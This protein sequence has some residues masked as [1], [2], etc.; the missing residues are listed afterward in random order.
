ML[1]STKEV[2]KILK[3]NYSKR[4]EFAPRSKLSPFR[5][6]VLPE[7]GWCAGKYTENHKNGLLFFNKKK[8]KTKKKKK[9]TRISSLLCTTQLFKN[10]K[11]C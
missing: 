8:K 7:G 9:K 11:L 1:E 10:V 4:K 2:T 3:G 6:D 5:V